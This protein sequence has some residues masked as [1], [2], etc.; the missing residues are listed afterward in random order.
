MIGQTPAPTTTATA[1]VG[2]PLGQL[3]DAR[4]CRCAPRRWS[5]TERLPAAAYPDGRAALPDPRRP[6]RPGPTSIPTSSADACRRAGRLRSDRGGGRAGV[7]RR[8]LRHVGARR[9]YDFHDAAG[10][11]RG[12]VRWPRATRSA[13]E[14][15]VDYDEFDLLP[16]DGRSTRPGWRPRPST[17]TACCSRARSPTPTATAAAF[18]F[19][20]AG[21]ADSVSVDARQGRR[22][23]RRHAAGARHP[24]RLR[25]AAPSRERGQPVSVRTIRR[26]HHDT[27]T[28]VPP[29]ERD[30]TIETVEYSDGFGRLL[31][32]RTQAED[33]LFG[34]AVVRRRRAPGRPGRTGR[35]DGVGRAAPAGAAAERRRQRLAGLRQ[36]GPG[37][38]EVRAVLRHRL[39]LSPPADEPSSAR[40][41]RSST[42]RAAR[43][44][45]PSTPTAREQRVVHGV[46][47]DLADPDDVRADAVGGLHLR[48]QRQRRPH[49]RRRP[50]RQLPRITGTRRR[51]VVVDALGRTVVTI[52]RNRRGARCRHPFRRSRSCATTTYDIRGNL[53]AVTDALGPRRVR[54]RLRPGRPRAAHATAS[55]PAVATRVLDALG[56]VDRVARR[57]RA[58]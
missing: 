19:S 11:A 46:P 45:A 12:L 6:R 7:A 44:S 4:R 10:P 33:V 27:D 28:D 13:R 55:T 14:T 24:A 29:T 31:Q 58:R 50:A 52:A 17:T 15:V 37:G 8:L 38:R 25:P 39:G 16:V 40:R 35:G 51:S 21:P 30:A 9:R 1:F 3:G 54:A 32:T 20:P 43:R 34:D 47:A 23:G 18:T 5:L 41:R 26:V 36:Q 2:L 56:N 53:L 57:A 42:T 22:G 48:R 49:P